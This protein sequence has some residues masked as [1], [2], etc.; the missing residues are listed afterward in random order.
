MEQPSEPV[1][2]LFKRRQREH[3]TVTCIPVEIERHRVMVGTLGYST[4]DPGIAAFV[5]KCSRTIYKVG[6]ELEDGPAPAIIACH[7]DKARTV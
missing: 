1:S 2:I 3:Y 7:T 6:S 5:E 4:G